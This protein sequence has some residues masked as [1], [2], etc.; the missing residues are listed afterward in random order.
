MDG[1][2]ISE[3]ADSSW[4]SQLPTLYDNYFTTFTF[5]CIIFKNSSHATIANLLHENYSSVYLKQRL[6]D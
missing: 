4:V 2:G 1:P 5:R 6:V 3:S